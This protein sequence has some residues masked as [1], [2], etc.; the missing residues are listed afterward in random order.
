MAD[1]QSQ[2]P[3]RFTDKTGRTPYTPASD[4]LAELARLIGQNDPFAEYGRDAGRRAAAPPVQAGSA[5]KV[6]WTAPVPGYAP[7]VPPAREAAQPAAV[8]FPAEHYAADDLYH[9]ESAAPDFPPHTEAGDYE[10]DHEDAGTAPYGAEHQDFYDDAQPRRRM[11]ILAIAAVFALAVIGTAGAFGYRALFGS[12]SSGP[13]PVI[14][15]DTAPSK[16]VKPSRDSSAKLIQD[17][18]PPAEKL[19]SREE[20]PVDIPDKQA[21]VFPPNQ[22]SVV[23]GSVQP[24]LGSGV[25]GGEPKKIHTIIIRPDQAGSANAATAAPPERPAIVAP[26]KPAADQVAD[27]TPAAEARAAAPAPRHPR[28]APEP[29]HSEAAA[30]APANAPLSLSPD[31]STRAAPMRTASAARQVEPQPTR[32]TGGYAVQISS[33]RSEADARAAFRSLQ[34]KFPSQLAGS[35]PLIRRVDLG[36]KG[37]YYRAMIGPFGSSE[38]ASKLCS[39]LKAAGA[40]CFVQRI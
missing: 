39:S 35:Q 40:S 20:K 28:P 4:P 16:I 29:Q 31:T 5:P 27:T 12:N 15:A 23:S 14:K 6:D 30:P 24:P 2:R 9:T 32:A 34:A 7:R 37:V 1:D 13:P 33:R 11:G 17:R 18:A 19:V 36:K 38:D 22:A 10:H 25:V 3:Y 8:P 26:N 21:G